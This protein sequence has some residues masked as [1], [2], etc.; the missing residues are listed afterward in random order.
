MHKIQYSPGESIIGENRRKHLNPNYKLKKLREVSEEDVVNILGHRN[1]GEAYKTV[2]PPLEEM[3]SDDDVIKEIVEPTPGAKSGIRVRYIQFADSMYNA[4]AQPYDR[5]RTYMRRYRGVDTG[6]LSGRQVIEVRELD[7]EKISK[8][9]IETELFDPA[10][11]GMRGATVHGH[12]LRLDEN[13]LMFDGLQRYKFN[14]ETGHVEYVKEQVGIPLDEPVDVGAP[15]E[16]DLLNEITTI[17]RSDNVGLRDDK[18][19]VDVVENI[20]LAR[21]LGGFGLDVFKNDLKKRLGED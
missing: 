3:D 12:S 1:P 16:D 14:E 5:A 11:S 9:L 8:E 18:E 13:G 21:T 4:P 7:L 19:V 17:Y 20:H 2:H 10:R 15:L 6:T